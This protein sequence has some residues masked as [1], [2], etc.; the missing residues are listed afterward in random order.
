MLHSSSLS[1]IHV[2]QIN[3]TAISLSSAASAASAAADNKQLTI[4]R[5]LRVTLRDEKLNGL[6]LIPFCPSVS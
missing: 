5:S 2:H 6:Q 1:P 3:S 4:N